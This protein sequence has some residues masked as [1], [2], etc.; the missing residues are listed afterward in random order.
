M[1][2]LF[3][4]PATGDASL[5]GNMS[6]FVWFCF[7]LFISVF[8]ST[9]YRNVMFLVTKRCFI[10]QAIGQLTSGFVR[11]AIGWRQQETACLQ[12]FQ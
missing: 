8:F 2:L 7:N 9:K 10:V 12:G 11:L 1:S 6:I 5:Q 3:N 4:E